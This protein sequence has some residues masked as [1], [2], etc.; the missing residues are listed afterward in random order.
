MNVPMDC[1]ISETHSVA[2]KTPAPRD[3]R[4]DRC[5][6]S[7]T[8]SYSLLTLSAFPGRRRSRLK[9]P[10]PQYDHVATAAPF[11]VE[12]INSY[13]LAHASRTWGVNSSPTPCSSVQRSASPTAS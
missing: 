1:I 3:T 10:L 5:G 2:G 8:V 12:A 4:P 13:A 7:L 11:M 6:S 9:A